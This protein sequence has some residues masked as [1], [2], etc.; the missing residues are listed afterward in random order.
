MRFVFK[1]MKGSIEPTI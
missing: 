1:A